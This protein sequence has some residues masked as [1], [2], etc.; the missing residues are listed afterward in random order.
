MNVFF[1]QIDREP[2]DLGRMRNMMD[3]PKLTLKDNHKNADGI[4]SYEKRNGTVLL[5][6][7][8]F[9]DG[10]RVDLEKDTRLRRE[11]LAE[12]VTTSDYFPKA[13]VNRIWGHL[14][15][16]GMNEQPAVDDFGDHNKVVHPE[17]LDYL[18]RNSRRKRRT[19]TST[20]TTL[21]IRR[22]SST[23]SAPAT[24]TACRAC[25]TPRTKSRKPRCFSAACCLNR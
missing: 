18:A 19:T 2:R 8:T 15:G 12:M 7:A 11:I 5:S 4:V 3:A 16:R 13:Y 21:S 10:R 24:P 23:G 17:L 9:L 22:S 25:R 20:A 14:F 6:K 1:K